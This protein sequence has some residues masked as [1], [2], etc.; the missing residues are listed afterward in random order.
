MSYS[1]R[2]VKY[3]FPWWSYSVSPGLDL[4][5]LGDHLATLLGILL[6][7]AREHVLLVG[8]LA[9]LPGILLVGAR[10]HVPLGGHLATLPGI[11]LVGVG[12]HVI[13]FST[14]SGVFLE[15]IP[16]LEFPVVE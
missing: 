16:L 9:T 12:Q 7:S 11:L 6:V 10:V 1:I 2:K 3:L 4:L 5:L 8:H 15:V 13:C 14:F